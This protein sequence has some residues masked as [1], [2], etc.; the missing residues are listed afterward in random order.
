[1]RNSAL[2]LAIFLISLWS[3]AIYGTHFLRE[4]MQQ[5]LFDQ[6]TSAITAVSADI[7][8]D[9]DFR[10]R[11]LEKIAGEISQTL[12]DDKKALQSYLEG[13]PIFQNLFNT[14][15][16]VTGNDGVAV[17]CAPISF[18]R[19][20]TDY[21][22]RDYI[23]AA[24]QAGKTNVGNVVI[25]KHQKTPV[26][27]MAA[28]I[29][30]GQGVVIGAIVGVT[31]LDKPNFLD[32]VTK[33]QYGKKG[34][35]LIVA[36]RQRLI[37]TASDKRRVME[38]L[39]PLGVNPF[40]DGIISGFESSSL[41]VTQQG[42]QVLASTRDIPSAEWHLVAELPT[43]EAFAPINASQKRLLLGTLILSLAICGLTW[44]NVRSRQ[45][46][47]TLEHR[48]EERARELQKS[49]DE[50][51]RTFNAI[52][53][54]IMILD[55]HS[56][57]IQANLAANPLRENLEGMFINRFC[58]RI[59]HEQ[60]TTPVNCPH[61]ALLRDGKEH[62]GEHFDPLLNRYFHVT[63]APLIENG[64]L[65]G[66]VHISRDITAIKR[67]ELFEEFRN[68]TLERLAEG[69][70][71]ASV[72]E[73]IV[74]GVEKLH[75]SSLCSIL[76]LENDGRHL[77][78][79]IAPNLP[80][81][82]NAAIDGLKIGI[83]AGSCGTAAY[84]KERV[85]VEEIAT[86]PYWAPVKELAA[87]AGLAACWSQPILSSSGQVLGTF[88]I[89][90]RTAPRTP[91]I[92]EITTIEHAAR[93]A[94]IAI[95]KH[96][97]A[98]ALLSSELRFRSFVENASDV[99]F[100]LTEEG[101]FAYVSPQWQLAI[102]Y[103]MP[104]TIGK[105]FM[106]FIHPDD[107]AGC[108]AVMQRIFETGEKQGEIEYRVQ[109]KDG[110]YLWYSA[111]GS[112][113]T[114]PVDGTRTIIGIGRD[115]TERKR[116]DEEL[117]ES[118]AAAEDSKEKLLLSAKAGGVAFWEYDVV[119]NNLF[120]DDQMYVI[121]GVQPDT[122]ENVYQA[123]EAILHPDDMVRVNGDVQK[124]LRGEKE[125]ELD[126]RVVWPD[127]SLHTIAA[128]GKVVRDA[129]GQPVSMV[130][131]NWD[132]TKAKKAEEDILQFARLINEKNIALNDA[133]VAAEQANAAKSQ[134]LSN[135][136]HEIRTPLNAIIGYSALM[137]R[138]KSAGTKGEQDFIGKIHTSGKLLLNV[139]NDILDYSKIES[140]K[141]ALEQITFRNEVM[142]DN[143]VSMM[144]QSAREKGLHLSETVSA[145]I[146]PYLIGDPH[147]LAQVLA[148]LLSNAVKFT[149]R[150]EVELTVT[151]LKQQG[152][153]QLLRF[154]VRDTGIGLS[155]E[156][157]NKLFRPFT[158]ADD[159]TTRQFGG[160]GL[161]LSIS[162][163]L[164]ELMGG[165]IWCESSEGTG[166]TFSFTAWF[167]VGQ[168]SDM[169]RFTVGSTSCPEISLSSYN[170]S[171]HRIL[172]V[173][174]NQVNQELALELLRDTGVAIDVA[175]NGSE[176]V[177]AVCDSGTL[178]DLVLM[179]IQMPVMDGYDATRLIRSDE[180]FAGLPIIAMTAHA[181]MEEQFKILQAGM[182]AHVAKPVDMRILLQV[183]N[184]F[185][186]NQEQPG[187]HSLKRQTVSASNEAAS[188][189]KAHVTGRV[190]TPPAAPA[191]IGDDETL[192]APVD[193]LDMD[194]AL[195]R[196]NGKVKIYNRLLR[197]F[198]ENWSSAPK[199]IEEALYN[200]DTELALRLVHTA[201]SSAGTIGA[202]EL[203]CRAE[204]LET[205][206][207]DGNASDDV[208]S[209][210]LQHF[211]TELNRL[212][213]E[214]A[215]RLNDEA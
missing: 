3:I 146:A 41:A 59:V 1:M 144:Q 130:G 124:A 100:M 50:W 166:S 183:M 198:G 154:S 87:R 155:A 82:Y 16:F 20:G 181:M 208:V 131:A 134:F 105:S 101:T 204:T 64:E 128:V 126:F 57:I 32:R 185:L 18:G 22:D 174:D 77:G 191:N 118:K 164:V 84:T 92:F 180:R 81:F 79:G 102:G 141:M 161:G 150:G 127:G 7:D 195:M 171:G 192:P 69:L 99:L 182:N 91:E 68:G 85:I 45:I 186:K 163:Q 67:A 121:Y 165:E 148:N 70:P 133:L 139:V 179:D 129:S 169:D 200:G 209:G 14:G 157:I 80:D 189:G 73:S 104:E 168:A 140:G 136:S 115:I 167:G 188:S 83:G 21:K 117:S 55:T 8:S 206:L 76:L 103:A 71:R 63:V 96:A 111:T 26:F 62:E 176:A 56:R 196:L 39:P 212:V 193:G 75:P 97:S 142:I 170:F 95:E 52:R 28:P 10:L 35:Y 213:A 149:M 175:N 2:A 197:Q 78:R 158:Q 49:R 123:W 152:E 173:E 25:G 112:L 11:S 9:I 201:K 205:A 65:V 60:E 15:I 211:A 88:A 61:K 110:S 74:L 23:I 13:L 12:L 135:M 4:D 48:V 113:A 37:I 24:L 190:S 6:Q 137:Q 17:A 86:H 98:D 162:K 214:L 119:N 145:D 47:E 72:L 151:L 210:P 178:Y 187:T 29:R 114:D 90:H 156:Q 36:P 138:S 132:V 51:V 159:S 116:S 107:V 108:L 172:L 27:S 177:T 58:H 53:D 194:A 147:R 202:V 66:S 42:V 5:L 160:T 46:N 215:D 184:L 94:S 44:W 153:Q 40:V 109:C 54:K 93:M 34:S 33:V 38:Q 122:F 106:P 125:Y 143:M 31:N 207:E 43:A 30:N 19:I 89:Y 203:S 199:K 120:W